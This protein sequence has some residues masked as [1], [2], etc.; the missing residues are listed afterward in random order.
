MSSGP[1]APVNPPRNE[2]KKRNY[3]YNKDRAKRFDAPRVNPDAHAQR[4]ADPLILKNIFAERD[5]L[6]VTSTLHTEE[7]DRFPS[8][9]FDSPSGTKLG[10]KLLWKVMMTAVFPRRNGGEVKL[11]KESLPPTLPTYRKSP[12]K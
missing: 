9:G 4:I 6:S 10:G 8:V 12:T 11:A 3:H 5:N 7:R 2:L 1:L